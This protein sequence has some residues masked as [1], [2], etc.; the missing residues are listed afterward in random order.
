MQE[1]RADSVA[2]GTEIELKLLFA[3]NELP[4][5]TA[6]VSKNAHQLKHRRLH[7]VYFD[8]GKHKLWKHGLTL[9]V[10]STGDG[11]EQ[12]IKRFQ[13][14]SVARNEW[15]EQIAGPGPDLLRLKASPIP[16]F[17]SRY[18]EE[19]RLLPVFETGT[20]RITFALAGDK[21]LIEASI[22]RG[23][24]KAGEAK[25]GICEL[26]LELKQG[27]VSDLFELAS[28]FVAQA[29]LRPDTISKAERGYLLAEGAWGRAA[30]GT[31]PRLD[32]RMPSGPA[33]QEIFRT[34]LHDFNLNL[35]LIEDIADVEG[36]HQGRIAI[37]RIRAAMTLFRP[38]VSD[39]AFRGLASELKWLAGLLG[40]ARDLDVLLGHFADCEANTGGNARLR[41]I[42]CLAEARRLR[43]R[44]ALVKSL[45]G[46][47]GRA[48]LLDLL[49]WIEA[50]Q[51]RGQFAGAVQ[52]P[53]TGFAR[54]RL[55]KRL[56]KLVKRGEDLADLDAGARHKIRIEAKKLR[57]MAEFFGS[58]RGVAKQPKQYKAMITCCEMLQESLGAI[59]DQEALDAFL[60]R[61]L[62]PHKG[63][64]A[65]R[66]PACAH[67][68]G[69]RLRLQTAND[70][71]LTRAVKAYSELAAVNPF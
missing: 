4:K 11:Y 8:T 12:G 70:M 59:R 65:S 29:L 15:E 26:E 68:P 1:P 18:A 42:C 19:G 53:I 17:A 64:E 13:S 33:F 25:L 2:A 40:A 46:K 6:L 71:E 41:E 54:N 56:S 57:Y 38:L 30:K 52:Q 69:H 49:A 48:L 10:R 47:R 50:G 36:L 34:C 35:P 61:E 5:I 55:K 66:E 7:T 63:L 62:Q 58:A 3:E 44:R 14:S 28:R 20:D 27:A 39:D 43:A 23:E 32:A 45:D 9:R 21:R 37:R 22:D 16:E 60:R 67:R 51:W 31:K 24:I